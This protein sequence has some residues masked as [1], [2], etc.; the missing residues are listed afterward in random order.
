MSPTAGHAKMPPRRTWPW[1]LLILLANFVVI[2]L[3]SPGGEPSITVPYTLFKEEASKGNVEAIYSRGDTLTGRFKTPLT[4]PP[5]GEKSTSPKADRG[6]ASR[7]PPK[8][9]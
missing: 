7:G 2:R 8:T 6:A 1:F 5:P 9:A 4:W 3:M